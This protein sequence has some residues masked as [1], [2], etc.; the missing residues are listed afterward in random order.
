MT[1]QICGSQFHFK[2][3]CP[4]RDKALLNSSRPPAYRNAKINT[5]VVRTPVDANEAGTKRV[6]S[7][8]QAVTNGL[9]VNKWES[10]RVDTGVHIS[11]T[12]GL[13]ASTAR[14]D[15][16]AKS[17][18]TECTSVSLTRSETLAVNEGCSM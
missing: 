18:S 2:R 14:H 9:K 10:V 15:S 3:D 5:C 4:D 13:H 11:A 7:P 12:D 16:H 17:V 1:C 6:A 8:Q